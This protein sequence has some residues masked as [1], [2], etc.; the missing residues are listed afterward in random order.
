ML[1]AQWYFSFFHPLARLGGSRC[2]AAGT[3]VAFLA[4]VATSV[5]THRATRGQRLT[6][7]VIRTRGQRAVALLGESPRFDATVPTELL[8]NAVVA[9]GRPP[10]FAVCGAPQRALAESEVVATQLTAKLITR[11]G[12]QIAVALLFAFDHAVATDFLGAERRGDADERE[13]E[14][15][16]AHV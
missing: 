1:P 12:D 11:V 8:R 3:A 14:P 15:E 4:D 6:S 2:A 10:A 9:V 7:A 13:D 16:R 5:S